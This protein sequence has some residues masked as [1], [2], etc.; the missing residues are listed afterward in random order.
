MTVQQP[1]QQLWQSAGASAPPISSGQ[2]CGQYP[3]ASP[4][5][6]SADAA[7]SCAGCAGRVRCSPAGNGYIA[8]LSLPRDCEKPV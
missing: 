2:Q 6:C 8:G 4:G 1:V 7:L 3:S 5:I